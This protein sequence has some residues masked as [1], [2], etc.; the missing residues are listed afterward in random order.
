[1][2]DRGWIGRGQYPGRYSGKADSELVCPNQRRDRNDYVMPKIS[3][4]SMD[5][6][7]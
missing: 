2:L 1:M 4:L 5:A 6:E 3:G 7:W